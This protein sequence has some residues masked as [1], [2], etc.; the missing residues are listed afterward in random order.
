MTAQREFTAPW[1][2]A[3]KVTSLIGT[4][5]LL[6]PLAIGLLGARLPP[7]ARMALVLVGPLI[8]FACALFTVRGYRVRQGALFVR[9][10]LWET[11]VEL[12][13]L[14]AVK[15][16]DRTVLRRGAIRVC[17]N[18]GL[19]SFSGWYRSRELGLFRM[20]ATDLDRLVVLT[21]VKGKAVVSPDNSGAFVQL[22][23]KE[24]RIELGEANR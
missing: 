4:A 1:G 22:L 2:R 20:Y 5:A 9:R 7:A 24:R 19:F 11:R 14:K 21:F 6:L 16:V 3:L 23:H 17:G 8:L 10:L 13:G 15:M 18:G 12:E